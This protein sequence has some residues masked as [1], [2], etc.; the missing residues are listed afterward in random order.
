ML[1]KGKHHLKKPGWESERLFAKA[2]RTSAS[3]MLA[4]RQRLSLD[5]RTLFVAKPR[6]EVRTNKSEIHSYGMS[7]DEAFASEP[8]R[9]PKTHSSCWGTPTNAF[10]RTC[11]LHSWQS[12]EQKFERWFVTNKKGHQIGV[13]FCWRRIRDSNS[14]TVLPVTRFPIVR[15]RPTRRILQ[16]YY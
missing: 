2:K 7:C 10:R 5:L 16:K 3:L 15:P 13:L 9:T 14:G 4:S 8:T 12:H 11:E 6:A 1:K